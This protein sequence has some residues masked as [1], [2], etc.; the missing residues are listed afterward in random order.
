VKVVSK[1][2]GV[3][4][5]GAKPATIKVTLE[6]VQSREFEVRENRSGQLP[7]GFDLT[8]VKIEP[9]RVKVSGLKDDLDRIASVDLDANLNA[10][11]EGTRTI[12]NDL[13]ARNQTG[14]EVKVSISPDRAQVTYEVRQVFVQRSLPVVVLTSGQVA[15]GYRIAGISIEPP[16]V[17]ASGLPAVMASLTQLSTEPVP[18]AGA[19]SEIRL[20]R[21]LD[22]QPDVSVERRTVTVRID[23]QPIICSAAGSNSPCGPVTIQIGVS[24]Q[25]QPPNQFVQGT[26]FATVQ[27][28]GPLAALQGVDPRLFKATVNLAAGSG[29]LYPVTVTVPAALASQ[30]V[31]AEQPDPIPV[32]LG[33]T[34]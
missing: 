17:S 12:P 30:G 10:L 28:T 13:H 22:V 27:L 11:T 24:P 6:E 16:I 18:L 31:R 33:P 8:V 25:N 9:P 19:T 15:A 29:G 20:I 1:R 3:E 21:N 2:H 34:P 5:V 4:V 7:S 26:L 14:G 23:V 32:I